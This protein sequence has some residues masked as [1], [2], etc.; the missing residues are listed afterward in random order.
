[1]GLFEIA[2]EPFGRFGEYFL[3]LIG[4]CAALYPFFLCTMLG[5]GDIKLMA[6]CMAAL[7]FDRGMRTLLCGFLLVFLHGLWKFI[8]SGQW[9]VRQVR[10]AGYLLAGFVV[11]YLGS[12]RWDY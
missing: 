2:G 10:L 7:G 9:R 5:A 1:M 3:L 8:K 12:W 11:S 6:V 4:T